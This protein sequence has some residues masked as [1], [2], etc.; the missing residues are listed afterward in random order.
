MCAVRT[1]R[2][3]DQAEHK[4]QATNFRFNQALTR[5]AQHQQMEAWAES[6]SGFLARIA[7]RE[8][9]YMR[10]Q[11]KKKPHTG[12]RHRKRRRK[13]RE[14]PYVITQ[15][16]VNHI[17]AC[18]NDRMTA[19]QV[20]FTQKLAA[21]R[22]MDL[23]AWMRLR[24][25]RAAGLPTAINKCRICKE[26]TDD[27]MHWLTKCPGLK[28]SRERLQKGIEEECGTGVRELNDEDWVVL[29]MGCAT[30]ATY[31]LATGGRIAHEGQ[32][33]A[34]KIVE[35][36]MDKYNRS[37][38][39]LLALSRHLEARE[40]TR[41]KTLG[42]PLYD[43]ACRLKMP[44]K[45][46]EPPRVSKEM[47]ARVDALIER[48]ETEEQTMQQPTQ[49]GDEETGGT[50]AAGAAST[51]I[52]N[53][54]SEWRE[55]EEGD[56]AACQICGA[57]DTLKAC[58]RDQEQGQEEDRERGQE[59]DQNKEQDKDQGQDKEQKQD[60]ETGT[61]TGRGTEPTDKEQDKR[62]GTLEELV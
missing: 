33:N 53:E 42:A 5:Q 22:H 29:A 55:I 23:Q 46:E 51:T 48:R 27:Y 57:P 61:R 30:R 34:R 8:N 15:G 2:N 59:Q 40:W 44:V 36:L 18:E 49:E 9:T 26:A 25:S 16:L 31:R 32:T 47:Q 45:P 37:A 20:K 28:T 11:Q 3:H 10:P 52:L 4:P 54:M 58:E 60:T 21:G 24:S 17:N 50:W 35:Y 1:E 41:L 12:E 14:K 43:A 13:V 7:L 39:T 56:M 62:P 6:P 19:S 38:E